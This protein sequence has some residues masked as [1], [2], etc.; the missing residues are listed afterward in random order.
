MGLVR[1]FKWALNRIS[2]SDGG[3]CLGT[4]VSAESDLRDSGCYG[5]DN[6]NGNNQFWS[7]PNGHP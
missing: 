6:A 4:S 5:V 3:G 2:G 7:T 1:M